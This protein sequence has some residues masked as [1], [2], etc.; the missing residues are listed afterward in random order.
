MKEVQIYSGGRLEQSEAEVVQEFPLVLRVNDREIVTLVASPHDLRFL[1]AGFL[2]VQGFVSSPDDFLVLSVCNDY[3]IANVRIRGELPA[4]LKPVLTSGCGTGITFTLP[5]SAK[6]EPV[7]S[8]GQV[9]VAAIFELMKQLAALSEKYRSH[10]GVHSAAVGDATG[11]LLLHAEDIGRHNTIDRLVGEALLKRMSLER[12]LLVS[13]GRVSAE[14][15]AKAA[16]LG[17]L[18]IASRTSPT[19]MAIEICRQAGITLIGYLRGA[20]FTVYANADR[21]KLGA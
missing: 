1:V 13:S 10:G 17:V 2:R 14:M 16:S 11:K 20:R 4:E 9:E 7:E 8:G 19:D 21:L 18:L 3:G 12:T 15:A 5:G 6:I